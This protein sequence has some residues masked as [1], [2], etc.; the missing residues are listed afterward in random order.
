MSLSSH[1]LCCFSLY[2]HV[3]EDVYTLCLGHNHKCFEPSGDLRD[4]KL[5]FLCMVQLNYRIDI[6]LAYHVYSVISGFLS[7]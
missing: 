1:V 2:D 3:I 6:A 7:Q 5:K 4:M